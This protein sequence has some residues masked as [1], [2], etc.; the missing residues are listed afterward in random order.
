MPA[1]PLAKSLRRKSTKPL[2]LKEFP[3]V[4]SSTCA[5]RL[6]LLMA[7]SIRVKLAKPPALKFRPGRATLISSASKE[8]KV[9]VV[10]PLGPTRVSRT[11]LKPPFTLMPLPRLSATDS[12]ARPKPN[13]WPFSMSSVRDTS[14]ISCAGIA[15]PR[16]R[17]MSAS[18]MARE[19]RSVLAGVAPLTPS[20]LRYW[21]AALAE[22]ML[23]SPRS[24]FFSWAW[25]ESRR[26][27]PSMASK[28]TMPLF[29]FTPN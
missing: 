9:R 11:R 2:R 14:L 29:R 16:S 25:A 18:S 27:S 8:P 28:A 13:N 23:N 4:S 24:A 22:L 17:L 20:V 15:P 26:R 10:S 7:S 6:M 19:K 3:S 1:A 5:N 21:M 12:A